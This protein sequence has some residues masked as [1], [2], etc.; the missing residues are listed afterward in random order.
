MFDSKLFADKP[1]KSFFYL[2]MTWNGSFSTGKGI[3][4]NVMTATVT[5]KKASFCLKFA[6]K[7]LTLHTSTPIFLV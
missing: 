7:L 4:I 3:Y 6:N 1:T 2:I 5:V